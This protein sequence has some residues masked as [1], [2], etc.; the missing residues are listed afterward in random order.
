MHVALALALRNAPAGARLA[1][2]W[3]D[4]GAWLTALTPGALE[5]L[6]SG[7]GGCAGAWE[8]VDDAEPI[9]AGESCGQ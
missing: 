7:P 2:H 1:W 6:N 3:D 4:Q 9:A 5:A 8:W